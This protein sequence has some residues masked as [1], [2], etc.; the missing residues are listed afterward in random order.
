MPIYSTEPTNLLKYIQIIG[1]STSAIVASIALVFNIL[2]QRAHDRQRRLEIVSRS[3]SD[4]AADEDM[5]EAFY[6]IEYGD[7]IYNSGFHRSE[8]EKKYDK[9]LRH[10]AILRSMLS[11]NLIKKEDISLV[12]YHLSRIE[13]NP[14]VLKY[15]EFISDWCEYA[16]NESH[17]F[18]EL[19]REYRKGADTSSNWQDL[20][21][22]LAASEMSRM[23]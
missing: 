8:E 22:A 5:Q 23:K 19:G 4:F 17:P 7:F 12:E 9:L 18:L 6:A 3:L 13:K 2:Q 15:I 20:N 16:G 11:K 21:S 10:F 14:E 1:P